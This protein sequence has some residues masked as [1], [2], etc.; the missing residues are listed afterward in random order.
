MCS[1]YWMGLDAIPKDHDNG[2]IIE[3]MLTIIRKG[4]PG[5]YKVNRNN[6]AIQANAKHPYMQTTKGIN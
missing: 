1:R 4:I 5:N 2:V 3:I 6:K